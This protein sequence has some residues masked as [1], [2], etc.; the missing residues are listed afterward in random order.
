MLEDLMSLRTYINLQ[1]TPY[2]RSSL[3][4]SR[5]TDLPLAISIENALLLVTHTH[6]MRIYLDI[7]VS[8]IGSKQWYALL[9]D[10]VGSY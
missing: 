6:T 2:Y 4:S 7:T 3:A 10:S 9:D 5:L 8:E 1:V